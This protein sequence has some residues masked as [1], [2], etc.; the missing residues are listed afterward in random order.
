MTNIKI[1]LLDIYYHI[2][3]GVEHL[4]NQTRF[5]QI[6]QKKREK[7]VTEQKCFHILKLH[8]L[9]NTTGVLDCLSIR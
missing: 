6:V 8:R 2:L 9:R 4:K 1:Q 5:L 7:N 3:R